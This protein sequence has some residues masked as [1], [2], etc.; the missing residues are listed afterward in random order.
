MYSFLEVMMAMALGM[1]S[2][3]F[4]LVMHL[5]W[6]NRVYGGGV[7]ALLTLGGGELVL[8]LCSEV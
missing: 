2:A 1:N 7:L 4:S 8:F 6:L 3:V 5:M